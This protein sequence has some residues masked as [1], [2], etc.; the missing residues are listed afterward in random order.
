MY[1]G[2]H[3]EFAEVGVFDRSQVHRHELGDLNRIGG[4]V[5][6]EAQDRRASPHQRAG[7]LIV[8]QSAEEPDF[9]LVRWSSQVGWLTSVLGTLTAMGGIWY[10]PGSAAIWLLVGV[11]LICLGTGT[12]CLGQCL[13]ALRQLARR[14]HPE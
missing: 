3:Q 4:A 5:S 6:A 9:S 11:V 2:P 1:S 7:S 12:A 8:S 10:Q 13:S 14:H